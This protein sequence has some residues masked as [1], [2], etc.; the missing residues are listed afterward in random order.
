MIDTDC[1]YAGAL[2]RTEEINFPRW[3]GGRVG[4]QLEKV[5]I[6]PSQPGGAGA[7]AELGNMIFD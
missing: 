6:K 1:K 5:E 2:L 4:G 7:V 3:P